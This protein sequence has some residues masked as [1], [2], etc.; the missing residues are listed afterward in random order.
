VVSDA[1]PADRVDATAALLSVPHWGAAT[2]GA[3]QRSAADPTTLV[4]LALVSPEF[5]NN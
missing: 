4:T 5:V 3:L 1:A 2:A